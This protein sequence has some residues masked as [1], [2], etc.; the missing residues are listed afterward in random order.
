MSPTSA[1]QVPCRTPCPTQHSTPKPK[2]PSPPTQHTTSKKRTNSDL[3][4]GVVPVAKVPPTMARIVMKIMLCF[5]R[6]KPMNWADHIMGVFQ[7]HTTLLRRTEA[8]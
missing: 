4:A 6:A 3:A 1:A 2:P 7:A 8:L 5:N